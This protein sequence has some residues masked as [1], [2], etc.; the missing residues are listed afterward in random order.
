MFVSLHVVCVCAC[1]RASCVRVRVYLC[2]YVRV[3]SACVCV[4]V[5]CGGT[6]PSKHQQQSMILV[7]MNSPGFKVGR[8]TEEGGE[9]YT[10]TKY[11]QPLIHQRKYIFHNLFFFKVSPPPPSPLPFVHTTRCS[12]PPCPWYP[13]RRCCVHSQCM[14]SMTRLMA[15]VSCSST[16]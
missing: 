7:P 12:C 13:W 10:R 4:C 14:G 2:V 11:L 6:A 1:L 3:R 15:T 16:T 5:L 9:G 8:G